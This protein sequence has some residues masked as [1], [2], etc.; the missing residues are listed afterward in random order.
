MTMGLIQAGGQLAQ[1]KAAEIN[2]GAQSDALQFQ[3]RMAMDEA[4]GEAKRIRRAGDEARGSALGAI[5][6]SGVKV[7]EGSTLEAERQIVQ[8]YTTDEY[9]AILTGQRQ[10][11]SAE[12]NADQVRRAGRD[13]RRA[14]QISA[15]TTLLGTA[16]QSAKAG[17]WRSKGPGFSGLQVP[18]PIETRKV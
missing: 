8:D 9:M 17:G 16:A 5:S 1:G 12:L 18:A 15:A 7:G 6:A 3:G 14:S 11:R 2:A 10:Q 4:Q 13:A